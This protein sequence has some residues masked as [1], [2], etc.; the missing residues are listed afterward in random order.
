MIHSMIPGAS[1]SQNGLALWSGRLALF[2]L[3][4]LLVAMVLHRFAGMATPVALNLFAVAL[5]I[6]VVAL[7]LAV[8][9]GMRIWRTGAP[10]AGRVAFAVL[11]A[12]AMLGW[13]IAYMAPALSLPALYDITTDTNNPPAF[14]TLARL[15]PK[16]ANPSD[17]PGPLFAIEQASAYPDIRPLVV[18][19]TPE[20][21]YDITR[22]VIKRRNWTIVHEAPPGKDGSPGLIEAVVRTLVLG[23]HD[24]VAVRI[25]ALGGGSSARIDVRSASRYGRHDLGRNAERVRSLIAQL[26]KRLELIVPSEEEIAEPRVRDKKNAR[27]ARGVRRTR[28]ARAR[29]AARGARARRAWQRKRRLRRWRGRVFA[30]SR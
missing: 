23:F 26:R 6:A 24:D 13:P 3:Q 27:K 17:Y 19:R 18:T 22:D 20:E 25:A 2:A 16:D 8:M 4:L 14:E 1:Q 29:R 15:R 28:R 12:L 9:A 7:L 10:G 30:P 21:A 11:I 5:A